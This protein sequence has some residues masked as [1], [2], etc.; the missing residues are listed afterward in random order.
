[1]G[2]GSQMLSKISGIMNLAPQSESS[3]HELVRWPFHDSFGYSL[4]TEPR[5]WSP[6][7]WEGLVKSPTIF[8][9]S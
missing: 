7:Q 1:M 5:Q 6:S 2:L 8:S 3:P 9:L 4:E